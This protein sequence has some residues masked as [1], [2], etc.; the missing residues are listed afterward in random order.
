MENMEYC[1]WL[2]AYLR[3]VNKNVVKKRIEWCAKLVGDTVALSNVEVPFP[4]T[5]VGLR[6]DFVAPSQNI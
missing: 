1:K 2:I 4:R 3:L 5:E 6:E